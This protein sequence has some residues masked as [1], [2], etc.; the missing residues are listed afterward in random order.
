[1]RKQ[2]N[3][4]F[5]CCICCCISFGANAQSWQDYSSLGVMYGIGMYHGN[6][7]NAQTYGSFSINY[8]YEWADHWQIGLSY[9][10]SKVGAM[11]A[12]WD[13]LRNSNSTTKHFAFENR[14]HEIALTPKYEFL[15]LNEGDRF[16]PYVFAGIGA[17][18]YGQPYQWIN[19]SSNGILTKVRAGYAPQNGPGIKKFPA[20]GLSAPIGLGVK[21]ALTPKIS[22]QLEGSLHNTYHADYID[23]IKGGKKAPF[24]GDYYYSVQLGVAVRL[25]NGISTAWNNGAPPVY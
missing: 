19:Q 12:N 9:F 25:G 24:G 3:I 2:L 10:T 16:T 4:F 5:L 6:V 22:F 15:N 13:Q 17:L 7:K 23:N 20:W 11:D 8:N 18:I 1:M 14:V 21:L